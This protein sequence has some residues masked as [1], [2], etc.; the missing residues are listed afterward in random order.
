MAFLNAIQCAS[1]SANTGIGSC[2]FDPSNIIGAILCPKNTS[3]SA[4]TQSALQTAL[5]AAA[6]SASPLTR[7]LPIYAFA[8]PKDSSEDITVQ[9]FSSGEKKVVREGYI[10]WEFQFLAGGLDLSNKIRLL[11]QG[12]FDFYFVDSNNVLLGTTDPAS[13][14]NIKAIPATGGFV[15]ANPWKMNDGSK[16]TAYTIR[17]VFQPKWIN[18]NVKYAPVGF[19]MPSNVQGL[20]DVVLSSPAANA[21]TGSFDL[22]ATVANGQIDMYAE[23]STLLASASLWVATNTATGASITISSVTATSSFTASPAND[24][25]VIALAT[26]APPYPA[27]GTVTFSLAS[28]SVLA[29]A[30][31]LNYVSNTV[32][33]TKS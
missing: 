8:E 28:P 26:T 20:Q 27:S 1:I 29:A 19:D 18:E 30:G 10:D 13:G 16:V 3:L 2:P 9:N 6:Q 33:I 24:G 31:I 23:Y 22:Q 14:T 12:A 17:F 5:E 25:W 7:I 15:R 21:T 4:T 11:N 32:A